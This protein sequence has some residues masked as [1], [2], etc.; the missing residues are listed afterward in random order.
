MQSRMILGAAGLIGTAALIAYFAIN[1]KPA[2]SKEQSTLIDE[3]FHVK[4]KVDPSKLPA[5]SDFWI[6]GKNVLLTPAF[7]FHFGRDV[8][9]IVKQY[10]KP[11]KS[12][13]FPP[14]ISIRAMKYDE[15]DQ[16]IRDFISTKTENAMYAFIV[17]VN[18]A[19]SP[20]GHFAPEYSD[21]IVRHN[22]NV[23]P[24]I[25]SNTCHPRFLLPTPAISA[26]YVRPTQIATPG[27]NIFHCVNAREEKYII[28]GELALIPQTKLDQ[29]EFKA[30]EHS[31]LGKKSSEK[32]TESEFKEKTE[33]IEKRQL[34][35]QILKSQS[36]GAKIVIVPNSFFYHIDLEM[37]PLP[38]GVVLLHSHQASLRLIEANK[39][40]VSETLKDVRGPGDTHFTYE[41]L[42]SKV[43]EYSEKT[44]KLF[45]KTANK[46]KKRGFIVMPVCGFLTLSDDTEGMIATG[47]GGLPVVLQDGRILYTPPEN[48]AWYQDYFNEVLKKAGVSIIEPVKSEGLAYYSAS[49]GFFR[50]QTNTLPNSIVV[51]RPDASEGTTPVIGRQG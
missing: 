14:Y 31:S 45:E 7:S 27:G 22:K 16:W 48:P 41:S 36:G 12:D 6:L 42:Y 35:K 2:E 26:K 44:E 38:N 46:L 32:Y 50:C 39:P 24:Y 33:I 20:T 3:P 25:T 40:Q 4:Y 30:V 9:S 29:K 11:S 10:Y 13:T 34:N 8:L 21:E 28:A 47:F 43:Q 49:H 17:G 18:Y 51:P 15:P 19:A 1:R 5:Q 23:A 37:C